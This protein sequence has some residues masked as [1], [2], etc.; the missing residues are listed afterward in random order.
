[1]Y[2]HIKINAIEGDTNKQN[3]MIPL[4]PPTEIHSLNKVLCQCSGRNRFN[5]DVNT[6]KNMNKKQIKTETTHFIHAVAYRMGRFV[7]RE[8]LGK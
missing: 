3:E 8:L 4:P 2:T 1:M 7:F 5:V 6:L